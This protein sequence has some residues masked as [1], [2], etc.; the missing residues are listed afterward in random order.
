MGLAAAEQWARSIVQRCGT[1]DADS[2]LNVI[3]PKEHCDVIGDQRTVALSADS[4]PPPTDR[5]LLGDIS[6]ERL[7]ER[8]IDKRLPARELNGEQARLREAEGGGE[9][10]AGRVGTKGRHVWPG[11]RETVETS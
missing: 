3:V 4:D 10:G 6:D 1:I 8:E 7:E 9:G 2:D 5:C 11:I